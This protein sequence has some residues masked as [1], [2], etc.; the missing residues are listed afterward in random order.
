MFSAMVDQMRAE[1]AA[2]EA[3]NRRAQQAARR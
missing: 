2:I 3:A 1:A